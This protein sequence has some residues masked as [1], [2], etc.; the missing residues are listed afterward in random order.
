MCRSKLFILLWCSS[1]SNFTVLSRSIISTSSPYWFLLFVFLFCSTSFISS[2]FHFSIYSFSFFYF[3]FSVSS[4]RNILLLLLFR[5]ISWCSIY[6]SSG[7]RLYWSFPHQDTSVLL[8]LWILFFSIAYL[9]QVYALQFL[10][11]LSAFMFNSSTIP[12]A[13]ESQLGLTHCEMPQ[14]QLSAA[15]SRYRQR[16]QPVAVFYQ[17]RSFY[18]YFIHKFFY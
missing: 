4:L 8:R 15:E 17:P 5:L 9:N 6:D 16:R 18:L 3:F 14:L 12:S 11:L 7:N 2:S 10:S 13:Q 1:K